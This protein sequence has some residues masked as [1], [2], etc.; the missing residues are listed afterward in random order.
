MFYI[1][2]GQSG[3][4]KTT[5]VKTNFLV[6]PITIVDDI[7]PYSRFS[8]GIIAL[9]KYGIGK[10]TEGTDTLSYSAKNKIKKILKRF[11]EKRLDVVLEGD[12]INNKEILD[13]ISTLGVPCKM[14]LVTCSLETSMR[15]LRAAGSKITLSFVKATKTKS[16]KNYL[17][18]Q[19]RFNGEII[20]NEEVRNENSHYADTGHSSCTV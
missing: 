10:R 8:N 4:G 20:L 18:Y 17:E 14:Y 11:A 2:I 12:R 9:G 13:Y 6:E 1:I 16:M 7:I 15:R 3:A 5:F 19:S